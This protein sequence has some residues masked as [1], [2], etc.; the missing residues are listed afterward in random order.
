MIMNASTGRGV[1]LQGKTPQVKLDNSQLLVTDTGATQGMILEGTDALLSLS[2]KSE[3]SIIGAG[4]GALE[5]IQIGNNNARPELSVTGESKVS[6]TT[7]SGTGAASDTENNAIHLRG[8]DPK[9][10][11]NDAELNIEILSGSRRGLYLNGINSDLRI[12]DSKIDIETL[13]NTG[14]RTLGNNGNNLISNSQID[15]LSGTSVSIGFTG[16]LMKTSISNNSK[17]NSDQAMYFA[18]QEVIFDNNSE[19]DITNTVATSF[20]TISDH[21]S[22]FGVLTFERR[23]STKGQFT[24]NHSRLSIDKRDR[25]MVRG[26]LNI[27]GGD[28][29]LLVENGGSLNIVNEGNGIPNDSTANN[30]NAGVGF[31][32][33]E[34]DPTLISN[35]DFIVRDPGSRI[36]IQANYGAA[37][38]MSTTGAVFDGSV[39]VENQGY[40]VA[41]GNTAGNSSGVFVGRL[42]HVTFDNPLFLDFTNYRTGGGQVFGVSN[43]NSTFTGINSDLSLWENNSDLLGD[44]FSN[45]RKLDYSFR[46]INY[47]TLVSSSD[48]DQLNTDTL[49]TTGLLP[50]T[51]ISSNNGRWAIADELRVPTN[52][53]KKIHGRVSLP[54]GLD[55]SRPA[56]DDEAI[57]TV[58]VESPS[59]ETTQEYTAKTVGDTNEA[60]GISIYG[61]EPRGGLFEIDL[62]EPLEAGSKVR[63]SKVELT[64]GE[65]TDGFEHQ[66]LTETVE[67][68]PIIPPTPAQFSS[69]TISQDST[70]IQGITDNLDAEVTATHNGEPLNTESVSVDADGR[71]S[72]DLSEVSLEIDDEIQVFLRDAE[73]SAVAAGVV[74]PPE[75]NNTRGNINPSTELIF[76]DVTFES[77]TILTV[78]DLG[79]I[80]PV[81]PLDPEIEVD[82]ENKPELPEDQGQLSI[83][84]VSSFN[85]GSQA[86]SVHDQ[87]YYAQPQRLLNED[88]TINESE[89]RPNYVQISDRR[90]EN[91]RNG[92]TLA[93]TQK[94]QFKGAENQVLNGARLSLS[95]QQVITAQ[96]GEAP[97]LQSAPVTLVPGNQRTLLQAQGSEGTGTWIYRFGDG[98]TAGESVAL[99]VPRGANP[100]AATY[101]STLIW[102][103]SAIPGN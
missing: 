25:Q 7:T 24:I 37:V 39:T 42:V 67:V 92:W 103:L 80:S 91:D 31:R 74:N 41:T 46:G 21:R 89:E 2:N 18:G 65:L 101:S 4:T 76:H 45:F 54:V 57:V 3:L 14:L 49:G 99:D 51:R 50:Y 44:P 20:T 60:P 30:A 72:L 81:D 43:A 83:D 15:L 8:V 85:F 100:E 98:E 11:F 88:G 78:G 28:N 52:A 87:T 73:G 97:G 53:D 10:I 66:I 79:P 84:F 1:Y 71:F 48:P 19:I 40:F 86:I 33:Y 9:A 17:I 102:E 90:S 61:E 82:P 63:I 29:E 6:V 69:S 62:D 22:R 56:W 5:N 58:E 96:G 94:E 55:D 27:L 34:S 38:T 70:T 64:S 23:G 32:N 75:T 95:N 35:N 68:F 47:N 16:D 12:L 36:D 26:A 13:R 77:A 93:V 59:G